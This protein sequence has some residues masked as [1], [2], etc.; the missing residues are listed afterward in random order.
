M[1]VAMI[2]RRMVR[3]CVCVY[4]C[5]SAD[6]WYGLIGLSVPCWC[7]SLMSRYVFSMWEWGG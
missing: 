4:V 6:V 2:G 5:M 1:H 7:L 3:M